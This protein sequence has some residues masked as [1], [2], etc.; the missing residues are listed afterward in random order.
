MPQ[1]NVN[2]SDHLDHFIDLSIESGRFSN[3]SEIVREALRLLEKREL[4]DQARLE[5][6]RSAAKDGFDAM[7]RGDYVELDPGRG[8]ETFLKEIHEEVVADLDSQ[9]S[10][11]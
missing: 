2:L 5:W 9:N 7:E 6:L 11:A 10:R 3:A 8:F 4:E 1:R